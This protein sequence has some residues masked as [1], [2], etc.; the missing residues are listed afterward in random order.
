M[1]NPLVLLTALIIGL[2]QLQAADKPNIVFILSDDQGS[3]DVGYKGGEIKTPH[4]DKL[5]LAGTQLDQFYV[6]PVCSPTR[7]SLMTGR[8]PIRYGLQVGVIRPWAKYGLPLEERLLPVVLKENGYRT[9]IC[10]KWHLGSFDPAYWPMQR[11]FDA[12]TGHLFGAIDY[13]SHIREKKLDWYVNG[14]NQD[15]KGYSTH[16]IAQAAVKAIEESKPDQ[17]LFL[18]VPFNAVH[19]PYQVPDEY[20]KGYEH[21]KG[22]RL[23]MAGMLT[24]LDEAVGSI[25]AAIENKGMRQNT[26]FI[27]SSDNGGV[28]P[29]QDHQQWPASRRQGLCLR[30]GSARRRIHDL[31]PSRS[32]RSDLRGADAYR[33]LVPDTH[34]VD[35]WF[36][37][38]TSATRRQGHLARDYSAG[39]V[40]ALRNSQ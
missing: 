3:Y 21:L 32:C 13:F 19:S 40:A 7:A 23:Q 30:R 17:P 34:Q 39:Q 2:G 9:V 33:R 27:Y 35:R 38:S 29:E 11:G 10:G 8:F 16:L 6:Q 1:R 20:K 4:I 36:P 12:H 25:V 26:L 18:Y 24:A 14:V 37:R 22:T 31:G 28:G 5:A 15:Q